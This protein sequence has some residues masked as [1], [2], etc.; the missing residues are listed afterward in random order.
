M[1]KI[2]TLFITVFLVCLA[3]CLNSTFSKN[4]NRIQKLLVVADEPAP[5]EAL[6][7]GLRTQGAYKIQYI[8]QDDLAEN[9]SSYHAVFMYIHGKMTPRTEKILIQY[10]QQGGRLIILH[11]GIASARVKN[12]DWLKLTGIYLAPRNHP[13][14]PWKVLG[15]TT[16]TMVNLQP[17]HYITSH[18][19]KYDR[20]IEYE[21]SDSPSRPARFPAI[22]LKNT[23]VFLNQQFT[24]GREKTV[25]FGFHC[26]DPQTQKEYRQDR[27]GWY[28]PAEKGWVFYYQAGHHASDFEHPAYLQILHNTL[29]WQPGM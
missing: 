10:A 24:D 4:Q 29:T 15:N 8:E 3:L 26:V 16:H 28:K 23:E 5:M 2:L 13:T 19:V 12:P 21:S 17:N 27:C 7:K 1:K 18:Q 14:R 11:H 9:L 22:E 25:L 6:A 20:T